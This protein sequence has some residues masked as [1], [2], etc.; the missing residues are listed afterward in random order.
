MMW[1]RSILSIVCLLLTVTSYSQFS[2]GDDWIED[3]QK[4][5]KFYLEEE[6]IYLSLIH[7]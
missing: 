6:G 7:I 2:F 4:Y 3:G 5:F 1:T